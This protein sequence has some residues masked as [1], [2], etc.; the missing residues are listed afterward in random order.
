MVRNGIWQSKL[1][2]KVLEKR[3][4]PTMVGVCK[5]SVLYIISKN[6]QCWSGASSCGH[7]PSRNRE[8]L[9]HAEAMRVILQSLPICTAWEGPS[10]AGGLPGSWACQPW[11]AHFSRKFYLA[12]AGLWGFIRNHWF[13]LLLS[14]PPIPKERKIRVQTR[15]KSTVRS[16]VHCTVSLLQH[17]VTEQDKGHGRH[18]LKQFLR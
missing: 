10:K 4:N 16:A 5:L 1:C 2:N 12:W 8:S 6:T 18:T 11:V 9:L 14:I 13:S 7:L 3:G 17:R 15:N